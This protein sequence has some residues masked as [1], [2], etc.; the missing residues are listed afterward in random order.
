MRIL[1]LG[2]GVQSSTLLLMACE[3]ELQI[4]AAIFADTQWE[5]AAV[6]EWLE[7]L[8]NKARDSGVPLYCVTNGDLRA[9]AL[10]GSFQ[11]MPLY[12]E[13]TDGK[14]LMGQRQCTNQYKLRPIRAK[15][16]ELNRGHK[17]IDLLLGISLDEYQRARDADVKWIT[18]KFPLIDMRYTRTD[19]VSWLARHGYHDVPKSSCIAC[20]FR[21]PKQWRTLTSA[22]MANAV[23]FDEGIRQGKRGQ[24]FVWRKFEPLAEADF[25]TQ[26]D[27]GQLDMFE[28]DGCGVLCAADDAI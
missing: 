9:D 17:P 19:C 12:I 7:L 13:T 20:P 24:Q 4:D 2:A 18:H 6:Y 11:A 10:A 16:R 28:S 26:Q 27:L 23:E 25:R 1:S 5:P 3:G 15:M 22:E 8:K 21:T 14:R